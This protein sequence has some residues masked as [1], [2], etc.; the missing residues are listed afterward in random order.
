[1]LDIQP[2]G[3]SVDSVRLTAVGQGDLSVAG[4]DGMVIARTQGQNMRCGFVHAQK[5]I[6]GVG[7]LNDSPIRAVTDLKGKTLGVQGLGSGS[8][9]YT[10][11]L[12]KEAGLNPDA[13]ITF[14]EVGVGAAMV[15]ALQTR[16]ID[17]S[18]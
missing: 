3:G 5:Q 4:C 11:G 18:A 13:D 2:T 10:K 16:R 17:A 12:V 7:V 6:Y 1:K 8:V 14:V 15:N 9:P